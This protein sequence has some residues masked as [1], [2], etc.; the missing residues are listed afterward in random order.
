MKIVSS[1]IIGSLS[2]NAVVNNG[3]LTA[4]PEK[5]KEIRDIFY[6]RRSIPNITS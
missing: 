4:L 3:R 5:K 6:L 2:F 1:N